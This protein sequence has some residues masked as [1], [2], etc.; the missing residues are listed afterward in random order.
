MITRRLDRY[1]DQVDFTRHS[2]GQGEMVVSRALNA[3]DVRP[4]RPW[5]SSRPRIRRAPENE[6]RETASSSA[7]E[8][9]WRTL[10]RRL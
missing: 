5:R 3:M 7:G 10:A 8:P 4:V 9:P 1:A 2:V 6:S